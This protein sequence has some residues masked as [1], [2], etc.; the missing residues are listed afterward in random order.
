MTR[1]PHLI[2]ERL[3]YGIPSATV[4]Q[5]IIYLLQTGIMRNALQQ[6]TDTLT[7]NR[8]QLMIANRNA[9][10]AEDA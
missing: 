8:G 7:L 3:A 2:N 6:N 10:T 1:F 9:G 5:A 4:S